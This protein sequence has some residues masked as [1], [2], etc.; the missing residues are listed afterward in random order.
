IFAGYAPALCIL[1]NIDQLVR[2]VG[3]IRLKHPL[4]T[5]SLH[6]LPHHAL[7]HG[8]EIVRLLERPSRQLP[9][10]CQIGCSGNGQGAEQTC[11]EHCPADDARNDKH[12]LCH[13]LSIPLVH[14]TPFLCS[15]TEDHAFSIL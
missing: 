2:V 9:H 7:D 1:H 8:V 12:G 15:H 14:V 5:E 6:H 11:H 10:L 13:C 3:S 4:Q